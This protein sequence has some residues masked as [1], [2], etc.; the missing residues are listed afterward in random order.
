MHMRG[1]QS[2][3]IVVVHKL[4]DLGAFYWYSEQVNLPRWAPGCVTVFVRRPRRRWITGIVPAWSCLFCR[5]R[6]LATE[7]RWRPWTWASITLGTCPRWE[8]QRHARL[9]LASVT[10]FHLVVTDHACLIVCGGERRGTWRYSTLQWRVIPLKLKIAEVA[11]VLLLINYSSCMHV[12]LWR[13]QI[14]GGEI[15]I[16]L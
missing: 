14:W 15:C 5:R 1:W 10:S 12:Q 8:R 16:D 11:L 2:I 7:R 6:S 9:Q 3:L 4:G 13:W